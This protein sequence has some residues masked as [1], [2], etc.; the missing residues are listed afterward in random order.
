MTASLCRLSVLKSALFLDISVTTFDASMQFLLQEISRLVETYLGRTLEQTTYTDEMYTGNNSDGLFLNNW[1]VTTLSAVKL[2][3]GSST[4]ATETATYY[5]LINQ[6]W[7]QYPG[8]GQESLATWSKWESTYRNGIKI[9]YTAGY[10]VTTTYA[11]TGVSIANETFTI[12]GDY[13]ATFTAGKVF[14]VT[15]STGND[16]AWT[17]SSSSL[18]AGSTV[19][20]VTGNV[21]NAVANGSITAS[22]LTAGATNTL[23]A[24]PRDLEYALAKL[25][26]LTWLEGR[27][28]DGRLGVTSKT[29][30]VAGNLSYE[31]FIIGI[32]PD[33]K[34]ILDQYRTVPM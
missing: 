28:G 16:G 33:I 23:W 10:P 34:L 21:T 13:T 3:D 6:R 4:Y 2:W 8:L 32:S 18:V 1:P 27:G 12:A 19:I 29:I 30:D 26:A 31:K 5:T 20:I 22:W 7:I 11:I 24:V 15:G 25:A 14:D 9:T 17:I